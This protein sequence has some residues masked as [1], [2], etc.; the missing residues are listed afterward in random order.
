MSA[1]YENFKP[2]SGKGFLII[3][4]EYWFWKDCQYKL[5]EW[6]LKFDGYCILKIDCV[7]IW[8]LD[9]WWYWNCGFKGWYKF[10]LYYGMGLGGK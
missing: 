9:C 8:K 1:I 10:W 7:C 5:L 6:W 3:I 4:G 2:F